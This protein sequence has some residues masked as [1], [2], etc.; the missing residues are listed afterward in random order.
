MP[1]EI[2]GVEKEQSQ[3]MMHFIETNQYIDR[4]KFF[5]E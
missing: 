3:N 2:K 1:T 5:S 4:Q